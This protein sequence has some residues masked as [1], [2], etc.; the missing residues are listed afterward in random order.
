[1]YR[2]FRTV[3]VL[4]FLACATTTSAQSRKYQSQAITLKRVIERE[5]FSPRPVND[6]F[7]EKLFTDFLLRLDPY[8]L[9][10]TADD[11]KQL[12]GCPDGG[13]FFLRSQ[14]QVVFEALH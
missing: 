2:P 10:F 1:M 14:D 3:I 13:S 9:Y 12:A 7:S 5:H 4:A 8:R 6:A 11:I